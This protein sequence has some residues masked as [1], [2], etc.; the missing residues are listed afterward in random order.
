MGGRLNDL[1]LTAL[2]P[3][4]VGFLMPVLQ[5][6]GTTHVLYALL[7]LA[8]IHV[9]CRDMC[10][11]WKYVLCL[12]ACTYTTC[13]PFVTL[14]QSAIAAGTGGGLLVTLLLFSCC[15]VLL[16]CCCKPQSK[17]GV[18]V[19]TKQVGVDVILLCVG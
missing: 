16:Y 7:V 8:G 2:S 17:V 9:C 5:N 13:I 14:D 3:V 15:F 12:F 1:G 6:A 18:M 19:A 4:H 10:S 11:T